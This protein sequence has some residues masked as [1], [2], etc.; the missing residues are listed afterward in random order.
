MFELVFEQS[1]DSG[2]D[3]VTLIS[4]TLPVFVTVIAKFAVDPLGIV[5]LFGFLVIEI[6]GVCGVDGCCGVD[7]VEL[8][9]AALQAPLTLGYVSLIGAVLVMPTS[10]WT[11]PLGVKAA[12]AMSKRTLEIAFG[13]YLFIVGGRFAISLINGQ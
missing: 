7:A 3:T 2:S 4:V 6:A 9:F 1:G 11:A 13:C 10:L 5:W 8:S 12:H